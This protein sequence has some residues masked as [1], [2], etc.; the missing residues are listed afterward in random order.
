MSASW[1]PLYTPTKQYPIQR[2]L[3]SY[4]PS[5]SRKLHA[6][7]L[8]CK[9]ASSITDFDLYDLLG[10]DNTSNPS[11]IK[12]AYR[13]L[14][15]HCHP[16]IAGPAGHDMA[17]ILN[18]AYSVLSDP[19]S[20][21]AY[22]KEQAKMAELRG[23]TGKPVYSVW[24]GS[25]SEQ[26]AVFVDEVKCIG[27]LKCALFAGKTFAVESVYGRAR[28]VAQW[29]D[30]EYKVM[31]AIEAC[32]VDCIS[33]VE[34]TDLAALEFLMSKQPRGNVRVG[35]GNTAGERVS[36]IFTDVKKFQ[37]RFNEA[38][39]KATKEQSKGATFDSEGQLAAIQAIRSISNWLFWQTATPVGPGSKQSQS[40]T[41]SASKF[42]PEINKLQAAVTA[43]KQIREKAEGRNRITTKYLSRDDYWVP[44]T[45]ALPASTQ[46][47]NNPISKPSVETK[48]T[49]QSRDL[50]SDVSSGV[51]VSPMRLI[52]PVSISIIAT[53]IIQQMVRNDGADELK[54]HAAGSMA[55]ELVNSHWMQVI[56]TG[57][58]WYIIGMA[59]TGMVEMIARKFRP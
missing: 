53:A 2:K 46:C 7:T 11:R 42:T 34:R 18:E 30:P 50:G 1:L 14:Q 58:T 32:P 44:T 9:A 56:L 20:R 52:L 31:E 17:I 19:S 40:L 51:H 10:I 47:P 13:A 15:K 3:G 37:I 29:A 49:K 24:L 45:F 4:N 55:L 41:R 54:E 16:D 23:Y 28:V 12:A 59:V 48:P 38:M 8:S 43:R 5:T 26:R 27:C 33:M 21:L 35:M 57:V 6:N 25:E 22:D 39:E 36:N